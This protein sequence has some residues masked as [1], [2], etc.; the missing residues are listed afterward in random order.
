[1]GMGENFELITSIMDIVGSMTLLI[2]FTSQFRKGRCKWE[3]MFVMFTGML[4]DIVDIIGGRRGWVR[5]CAKP[6]AFA[7]AEPPRAACGVLTR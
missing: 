2:F 4:C 6:P 5:S 7:S 3:V 1:M